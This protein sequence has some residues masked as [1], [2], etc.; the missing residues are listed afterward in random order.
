M[1]G[2]GRIGAAAGARGLFG[3]CR[4]C[5]AHLFV[6][7][8]LCGC[9]SMPASK[10]APAT[11]SGSASTAVISRNAPGQEGELTLQNTLDVNAKSYIWQPWFAQIEGGGAVGYERQ[12][13]RTGSNGQAIR[14][15]GDIGLSILP[16]SRFPTSVSISRLD[17]RVSGRLASADFVRDRVS[18]S[19][20]SKITPKFRT[21]LSGS[22]DRSNQEGTGDRNGKR[23]SA[24]ANKE[25]GKNFLGLKSITATTDYST[26]K[27]VSPTDGTFNDDTLTANIALQMAPSESV[28]NDLIITFVQD[29]DIS[30]IAG[31]KRQSIQAVDTFHWAPSSRNFDID[32]N[33][34]ARTEEIRTESSGVTNE[35]RNDRLLG[36][37]NVNIPLHERLHFRLGFRG[38]VVNNSNVRARG[39][40]S[41]Q[42]F[43]TVNATGN[44]TSKTRK[45]GGYEWR[46]GARAT[47]ETGFTNAEGGLKDPTAAVNQTLEREFNLFEEGPVRFSLTQEFGIDPA[48]IDRDQTNN[49]G[50]TTVVAHG[51]TVNHNRSSRWASSS[52]NFSVRDFRELTGVGDNLQSAQLQF[53]RRQKFDERQ[54]LT[55]VMTFNGIRRSL[56]GA[57][58]T[59]ITASGRLAYGYRSIFNILNL[60]YRSELAVNIFELEEL[61]SNDP[62][63]ELGDDIQHHEWRNTLD[64]RVGQISFIAEAS[65]FYEDEGLGNLFML[66]IQR[67]LGEN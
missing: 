8:L 4:L 33:L 21:S 36:I 49:S 13:G 25:F 43:A 17:S 58:D 29:D 41:E 50:V 31:T 35:R 34:R 67:S 15:S 42:R 66:R 51:L 16:S 40:N 60:S 46:W 22:F 30:K 39:Q 2:W 64:Y 10:V 38:G 44:Y 11:F 27:F 3:Y 28:R 65:L 54:S 6:P 23:L 12:S 26:S 9:A 59:F 47:G 62:T 32:G 61:F 37:V 45:F 56:N 57:D 5:A 24:S 55:G 18:F 52:F 20:R 48:A 14:L 63:P 7:V 1:T 19:N 53:N